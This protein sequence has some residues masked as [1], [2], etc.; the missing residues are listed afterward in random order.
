MCEVFR[1]ERKKDLKS[2][3][4]DN[5]LQMRKSPTHIGGD[6]QECDA[7]TAPLVCKALHLCRAAS[8]EKGLK[9]LQRGMVTARHEHNCPLYGFLS[10]CLQGA[11]THRFY[12]LPFPWAQAYLPH[13]T[14]NVDISLSLRN[15]W[16]E[17]LGVKHC[18]PEG[19]RIFGGTFKW[20]KMGF[21]ST[22]SAL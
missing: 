18:E 15:E 20:C 22:W 13:S 19:L 9:Q 7:E 5:L 4:H 17:I 11:D 2:A 14:A 16:S 12:W 10:M 3:I 1:K 6:V 21:F 8:R